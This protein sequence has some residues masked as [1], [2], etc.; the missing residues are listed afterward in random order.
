MFNDLKFKIINFSF[1]K[2]T[3]L[4]VRLEFY[5]ETFFC[6]KFIDVSKEMKLQSFELK[7]EKKKRILK[8]VEFSNFR[9][10]RFIGYGRSDILLRG[11]SR[12]EKRDRIVSNKRRGREVK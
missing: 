3:N 5:L 9:N 11:I 4:K 2:Y 8:I 12:F 1:E 6:E 10:R 7:K